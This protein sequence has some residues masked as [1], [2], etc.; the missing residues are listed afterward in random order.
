M[1][2]KILKSL[3]ALVYVCAALEVVCL[4]GTIY[5]AVQRHRMDVQSTPLTIPTPAGIPTPTNPNQ[6]VPQF[7]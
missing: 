4:G 7:H 2:L 1:N 6:P 5:T 3:T